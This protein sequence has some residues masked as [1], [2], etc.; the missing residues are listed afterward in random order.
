M[1]STAPPL[2]PAR[3]RFMS[4][5]DDRTF[6]AIGDALADD[7]EELAGLEMGSRLLDV[8]CGYGRLAHALLRRGFVGRYLGFDVLPRH[9]GWC[10][11][12]LAREGIEFRHVDIRNDRY[13]PDG[14]RP[15]SDLRLAPLD[16]GDFDVIALFS[17]FTHMWP[18]E[19]RSYLGLCES[20]LA[21]GG[22][23]LATFFLLDPEWRELDRRG[24]PQYPLP[25]E[26]SS[27]CRYMS[28]ENPLH[29]IAYELDWVLASV[30]EAGLSPAAPPRF[31]GWSGRSGGV[32]QQDVLVLEHAD[33]PSR[34]HA[35]P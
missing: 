33:R 11:K 19:I 34:P 16:A 18:E 7:L 21:P 23:V 12:H 5:Q 15:A 28:E 4:D 24:K 31:G 22:R 30:G 32:G 8:G 13:N 29:V 17:V 25:H 2:P 3:L 27:F 1:P 10:A 14:S 35:A 20:M 9:I 26:H 6:L